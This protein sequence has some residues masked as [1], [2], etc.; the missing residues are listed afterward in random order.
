MKNTKDFEK[1]AEQALNS[2]N[3]LQQVEPN[4]FLHAKILHR[5]QNQG[6]A[7][8]LYYNKLMVRLAAVLCL[9]ICVNAVS[10]FALSPNKKQTVT[11]TANADSFAE[12]YGLNTNLNSY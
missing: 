10:F 6:E 9:F 3:N 2:L 5:M 7:S 12:A 4:E 11:Q 1:Q 8:P